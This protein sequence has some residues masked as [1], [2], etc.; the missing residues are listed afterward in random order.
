MPVAAVNGLAHRSSAALGRASSRLFNQKLLNAWEIDSF[1]EDRSAVAI[2]NSRYAMMAW[3]SSRGNIA[4]LV[5]TRSNQVL[6]PNL[7][8]LTSSLRDLSFRP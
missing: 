6:P 2:L 1:S 4:N 3:T 5:L 8:G 7:R